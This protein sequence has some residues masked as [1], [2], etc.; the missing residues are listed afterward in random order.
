MTYMTEK[1]LLL[2]VLTEGDPDLL[3]MARGRV[4]AYRRS[5][6]KRVGA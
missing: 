6:G 4:E 2:G 3:A 5:L 1:A